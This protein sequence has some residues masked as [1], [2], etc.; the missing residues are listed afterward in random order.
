[1]VDGDVA[2]IGHQKNLEREK[3]E[4]KI[5]KVYIERNKTTNYIENTNKSKK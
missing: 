4:T 2:Y 1:L 3:K 5:I